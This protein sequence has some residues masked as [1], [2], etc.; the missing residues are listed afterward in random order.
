MQRFAYAHAVLGFGIHWPW[1]ALIDIDEFLFP[2]EG[3]SLPTTLAS[4]EHLEGPVLNT[5]SDDQ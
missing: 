1:V 4:Y 2:I 5:S 3:N